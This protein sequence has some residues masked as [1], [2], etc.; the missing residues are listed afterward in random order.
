M[1]TGRALL[2]GAALV[3]VAGAVIWI[4]RRP[5]ASGIIARM[6]DA[7]GVPA[8][9]V[10]REIG[11]HTQRLDHIV[12]GDPRRPDL[13]ADW[14]E[15][16]LQPTLFGVTVT[17]V[18]AAG[19]R[20]SG[21]ISDG[22]V[23]F[24]TIDRLLPV[25]D[26]RPFVLPALDLAVRDAQLAL[27]TPVG[28]VRVAVDGRGGLADGF[29]GRMTLSSMRLGTADCAIDR[30]SAVL[31]VAIIDRRP[32]L[33]GPL[34]G[35]A[36][37]CAKIHVADPEASVRVEG[38]QGF[39]R[40]SGT[41]VA[42][43]SKLANATA[44]LADMDARVRFELTGRGLNASGSITADKGHFA[45]V[46]V[47]GVTADGALVVAGNVTSGQGQLR[48]ARVT[49]DPARVVA[50]RRALSGVGSTPLGPVAARLGE[51]TA[52]AAR[53]MALH[54]QWAAQSRAGAA[55]LRISEGRL[56]TVGGASASIGGGRGV[57]IGSNGLSAETTIALSGGGF[58]T[59]RGAIT[60]AAD[61]ATSGSFVVA[62]YSVSGAS[63]VL[64]PIRVGARADG[65]LNVD[66]FV[67]S[68]GPVPGGRATGVRF[69][70]VVRRNGMG[71]V[72]VGVGCTP[73]T[74]DRIMLGGAILE[75]ARVLLCPVTGAALAT[76]GSQSATGGFHTGPIRVTGA[77][78]GSPLEMSVTGTSFVLGSGFSAT[79]LATRIG[80]PDHRTRLDIARI[81]GRFD[82]GVPHGE[83]SDLAGNIA[84]VPLALTA[85]RGNWRLAS[86]A[87]ELGGGIRVADMADLPRFQ[88][89]AADDARLTVKDGHVVA[90]ASLKE[91]GSGK[92]ITGVAITHDLATGTGQ[93][94]LSVRDLMFGKSLQPEALTRLTLGI[95]ANVQG[96]I[97]GNGII[98]WTRDKVT[99]GGRFTTRGLD[100]AAAF[101][102]V[103]GASGSI[104]FDD[105]LAL[106]TPPGQMVR[107]GLVNPG[108]EVRDGTITYQLLPDRRV[109][110]EQGRWPFAGGDLL[111]QP[112][113]L[114]FGQPVARHLSF[115]ITG[116]DAAKFID[117][118]KLQ[119][120]AATGTF[121]GLLPIVFDASGGRIEGGHIVARAGGGTLAYVGDVSNAQTNT[122]SRLAFDALKSIRYQNLAID[123]D[124]ALDGEI[125]SKVGFTGTNQTAVAPTGLLKAFTGLP[126]RFNITVRAPFRGL[127]NSARTFQDPSVLLD[128][129]VQ[130]GASVTQP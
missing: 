104:V 87:L 128:K 71:P 99:S 115:R 61:G 72:A 88:P 3:V 46:G 122:Y 78:G 19:V 2:V 76:I 100:F 81:G 30:A 125:V 10:V 13:T 113:I 79:H 47:S 120:I 48:A 91:P 17:G 44:Q 42:H 24:G 117:Q 127:V 51:A 118:L 111:L 39:A 126:F 12:I 26:G 45:A 18:R 21:R 98:R 25:A 63:L 84:G 102:P 22:R 116:L 92:T 74:F 62:P 8:S 83:F 15:V 23:S 9:Y 107:L 52:T 123:L 129:T 20:V 60:R 50:L 124:G 110:I 67:R 43:A 35:A 66:T 27:R 14:A 106:S 114:D 58:P 130:P 7:R 75:P 6:L 96:S 112:A 33:V 85:A 68:D 77:T 53:G 86:G 103:S 54:A 32:S 40:W 121:D 38:D 37:D 41:S 56:T 93:A 105:L 16:S 73:V 101:G 108:V 95:V 94:D 34:S 4:E 57:T 55:S 1:R 119:D 80:L 109:A 5:I 90:A 11:F 29:R 70:V 64:A 59:M 89:L 69:P 49:V 82:R 97:D 28:L 36:V 65:T 31:D